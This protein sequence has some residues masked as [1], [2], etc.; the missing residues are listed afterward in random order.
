MK[1]NSSMLL[2]II[3]L[4]LIVNINK[5]LNLGISF[6]N[7]KPTFLFFLIILLF[8]YEL[9]L[10]I[11]NDFKIPKIVVHSLLVSTSFFLSSIVFLRGSSFSF[12]TILIS[13]FLWS[14]V[15]YISFRKPITNSKAN[16]FMLSLYVIISSFFYIQYMLSDNRINTPEGINTVYYILFALP[17][18]SLIK[19]YRLKYILLFLIILAVGI[20]LKRTPVIALAVSVFLIIVYKLSLKKIRINFNINIGLVGFTSALLIIGIFLFGDYIKLGITDR[21]L[22]LLSDEGSGRIQIYNSILGDFGSLNILFKFIGRGYLGTN[23]YGTLGV[24]AHN[25]FLEILYNY[26]FVGLFLYISFIL[27]LIIYFIEK[28]KN[29]ESYNKYFIASFSILISVS[30][31]SQL[32][33]IP[34][35]FLLLPVFW[36]HFF[37][38]RLRNDVL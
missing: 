18:V 35:Y 38:N 12:M 37:Q 14:M 25:D 27:H 1:N 23:I 28:Y 20:S 19:N 3:L 31:F 22:S 4:L 29:K 13:N 33:L 30:M 26:G 7:I 15:F 36:G 6:L 17:L 24:G 9:Y 2:A 11:K 32:I 5:N 16:V 8:I 34:S 21:F 10:S